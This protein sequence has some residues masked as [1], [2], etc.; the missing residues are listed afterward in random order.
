[1]PRTKAA[2]PI[3]EKHAL[4][5][6]KAKRL[7]KKFGLDGWQFEWMRSQIVL[8]G[9][10]YHEKIIQLSL[11]FVE[12]CPSDEVEDTIR[13]EIAHALVYNL[14]GSKVAAHGPEWVKMCKVTG[15]NPDATCKAKGMPNGAWL[16][17]CPNCKE[18]D[19]RH[20]QPRKRWGLYCPDCGRA[21]GPLW[22]RRR[23]SKPTPQDL[24]MEDV[25]AV[26]TKHGMTR[27]REIIAI[28]QEET[29][30]MRETP[31]DAGEAKGRKTPKKG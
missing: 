23:G 24:S 20:G 17:R 18:E 27:V 1:M 22:Y 9:C 28:I 3:T 13:H 21:K 2:T 5:E 19:D 8:G 12:H 29:G 26:V 25:N 16:A 31:L 10:L 11:P 4:V 7:M 14:H 15:A 6:R 30:G